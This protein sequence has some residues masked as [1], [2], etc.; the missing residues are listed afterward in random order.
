MANEDQLDD[1]SD[2]A[3]RAE[4]PTRG[5][6][7]LR[8]YPLTQSCGHVQTYPSYE[9]FEETQAAFL[10]SRV[11]R[12]CWI[13]A[14]EAAKDEVVKQAE[15]LATGRH[16]PALE[17]TPKQVAW[18]TQVRAGSIVAAEAA[19]RPREGH[20]G[21]ATDLERFYS[22]IEVADAARW[23]LNHAAPGGRKGQD[24]GPR[25][26]LAL[27]FGGD[28]FEANVEDR[29]GWDA[30]R[31]AQRA[32]EAKVEA[33]QVKWKTN[34]EAGMARYRARLAAEKAARAQQEP[35]PAPA[36]PNPATPRPGPAPRAQIARPGPHSQ[37]PVSPPPPSPGPVVRSGPKVGRNAPC[38]C[39]SGKKYK[40]CCEAEGR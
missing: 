3:P 24:I 2:E 37:R 38:P 20:P 36:Q 18:A 17:G 10:A 26:W 8:E 31:A 29:G 35:S 21:N 9:P 12:A 28:T 4:V 11:C 16:V 5:G 13:A 23:W 27:M 39:G 22:G 34:F 25:E 15:A 30:V 33:Q 7:P 14:K 32:E 19:F 1:W 6:Q 40:K